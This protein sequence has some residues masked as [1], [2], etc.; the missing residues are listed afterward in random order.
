MNI[1]ELVKHLK[2][3][4][5]AESFVNESLPDI[6]YDLVDIYMVDKLGLGSE[7]IFFDAEKMPNRLIVEIGGITYENLFP[8]NL[9]Q[10][11]VEEFSQKKITDTQIA[12]RLLEYREKDA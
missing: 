9:A 10:E 4:E 12:E 3:F 8:L 11:L 1:V 6:E 2:S 7:I 5:E